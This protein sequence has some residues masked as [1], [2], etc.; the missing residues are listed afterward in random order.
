MPS[1][2]ES[3]TQLPIALTMG[4]PAG[5]ASEIT[6]QA[7]KKRTEC[8]LSPFFILSQQ[9][10]F[11]DIKALK[12]FSIP[13]KIITSPDET[14][15]V[16]S[17]A[18]P[19]LE[20]P[21]RVDIRLG[22]P[23]PDAGEMTM[24]AISS[25][26]DYVKR[27][28]ASSVVTNP[29]NKHV[30]Y[31]A[32]FNFP[33]H[34]EYLAKLAESWG[35]KNIRPVMMLASDKLRTVPLTIHIAL[36]QVAEHITADLILET[37]RILS[38]DLTKYFGLQSPRIA[39][40][41]LNP[42]AGENG[43]MGREEIEIIAPAI[44]SLRQEGIDIAGPHPADTL[45]HA[46]AREKYDVV[47]GMYHDQALIPLKTLGFDEGVNVTLGLPFIRTS[48]DHG[49]A[50]DIAG[51]GVANPLSLINALKLAKQMST[52]SMEQTQDD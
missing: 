14:N 2:K 38:T 35:K 29:I 47:L 16:F 42:H 25:A 10:L 15:D 20:L 4:D 31:E 6:V 37:A 12:G 27:G 8:G 43:A 9:S 41:G 19:I 21:E 23:N 7:W 26:V 28:L 34:I 22:Q 24:A 17:D 13:T 44:L 48:P 36:A 3:S 49:T 1:I 50:Y 18:L 32:G 11:E 30:L 51:K 33:G 52:R 45:F 40:A 46:V 39:V 5:I